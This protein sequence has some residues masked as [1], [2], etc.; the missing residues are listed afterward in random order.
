MLETYYFL[1]LILS[2]ALLIGGLRVR[3]PPL[4]ILA[5]LLMILPGMIGMSD[6]V[7]TIVS[8]DVG[9][10]SLDQN[11]VNTIT[12]D[13]LIVLGSL[14]TDTPPTGTIYDSGLWYLSYIFI[15]SGLMITLGGIWMTIPLA[16]SIVPRQR[17][18]QR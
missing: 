3:F 11:R 8:Y 13:P 4:L 18:F 12:G 14:S 6:G 5:G 15:V 10:D 1:S 7:G 2:L 16:A 9:R 17:G